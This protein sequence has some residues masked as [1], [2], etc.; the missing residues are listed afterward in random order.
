VSLPAASFHQVYESYGSEVYRFALY[1]TGDAARAEDLTAEAFLRVWASPAPAH[2]KTIKSYLLAIVR[3]LYVQ[4]WRRER[5]ETALEEQPAQTDRREERLDSQAELNRVM[6]ALQKLEP[7]ERAA[8]LLRG[9]GGLDYE[10]I[11]QVLEI[12]AVAARVRVH[13]ARKKLMAAR[14]GVPPA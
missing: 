10:E 4:T 3:N 1:L 14:K 12:S 2:L 7:V 13:R 6:A 9:E 8:V 11:A 5:R